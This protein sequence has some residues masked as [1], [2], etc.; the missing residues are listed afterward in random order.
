MTTDAL[1]TNVQ[2]FQYS[3][4]KT[5]QGGALFVFQFGLVGL[6]AVV[7]SLY[8]PPPEA[9]AKDHGEAGVARTPPTPLD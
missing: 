6:T 5:F 1:F 7:T 9:W 8:M 2:I 3:R 4:A